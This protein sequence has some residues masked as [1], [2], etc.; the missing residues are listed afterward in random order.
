[1]KTLRKINRI[2]EVLDEKGLQDKTLVEHFKIKKETVS[3]WINNKQQ[4][5]LKTL[6]EIA[7][8]LNVNLI[9]LLYVSDWIKES[10]IENYILA[11]N[12]KSVSSM[13]EDLST[14]LYFVNI[15]GGENTLTL[16]GKKEF[17][18][19]AKK[20]LTY[21]STRQQSILSF[22]H[23]GNT[24]E[25]EINYEAIA[26]MDFPNGTKAGEK[27]SLNAKS[28]FEFSHDGKIIKMTDI[29]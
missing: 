8:F 26:A 24:T 6:D 13:L 2:G 5:T 27:I 25:V 7:H 14:D 17:E 9:S 29:S 28:I 21:F 10:V 20:A 16:S 12:N 11:Y 18:K 15:V 22:S 1:M 4:P 19:Q 3:R 23:N